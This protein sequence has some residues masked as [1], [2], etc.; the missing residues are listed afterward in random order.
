M[1]PTIPNLALV[2]LPAC[3]ATP[4]SEVDLGDEVSTGI[5]LDDGDEDPYAPTTDADVGSSSGAVETGDTTAASTDVDTGTVDPGTTGV[6]DTGESGG[7]R[8]GFPDAEPFGDDV[9]ELDLV[10]SWAVPWDPTGVADVV[11][12]IGDDGSFTWRETRADC[13]EAGSASGRLWVEGTQLVMHVELWDKR[14]P[15]D[16]EAQLGEPLVA[17]FRMRVGYSPMGGYLGISARRQWTDVLQWR[18][19]GYARLD[20]TSGPT[21]QWAAEAELWA[22][23]QGEVAAQLLVRDRYE[24][25]IVAGGTALVD[26]G[27][28]WWWPAQGAPEQESESGTWSD[29]TPGNTAGA[30]TIAGDPFAYD[31]LHLMA[32]ASDRTF[33]LGVVSDCP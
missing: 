18:G 10:G 33:K 16:V 21:G 14:A 7:E 25:T 31:A 5:A 11:L 8:P 3:F 19:V 4:K 12:Q 32:F 24:A 26:H 15:W 6:A 1:R 9:R 29:D 20:A 27:W 30:A 13:S 22:I 28:T 23:P 17:P 2:F